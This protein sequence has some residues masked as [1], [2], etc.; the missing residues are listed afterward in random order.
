MSEITYIS[1][2]LVKLGMGYRVM[3]QMGRAGL[4]LPSFPRPWKTTHA[5]L[6]TPGD[7]ERFKEVKIPNQKSESHNCSF[8]NEVCC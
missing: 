2:E 6:G 7:M 1:E 5:K 3:N 8:L 4:L